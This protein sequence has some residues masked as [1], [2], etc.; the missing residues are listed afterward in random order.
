MSVCLSVHEHISGT[1]GPIITKFLCRSTV[2]VARSSSGSV[3]LCYVLLVLWMMFIWPYCILGRMVESDVYEW[4]VVSCP[5]ALC[6]VNIS[7]CVQL[8][9]FV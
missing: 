1:A 5:S 4:L 3:A 6:E 7:M 9:S 2:A 8:M